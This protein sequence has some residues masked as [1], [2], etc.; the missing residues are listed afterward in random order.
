MAAIESYQ[1][2]SLEY[3]DHLV[4]QRTSA[5]LPE[6]RRAA[7]IG[8]LRRLCLLLARS[9]LLAANKIAPG[10]WGAA[11]AKYRHSTFATIWGHLG[12]AL[13]NVIE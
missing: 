3:L 4:P 13:G 10:F 1:H 2:D 6:C 5:N 12:C 7:S 9:K 8:R 11:D